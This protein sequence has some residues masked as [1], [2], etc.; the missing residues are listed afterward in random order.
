MSA[1]ANARLGE[2]IWQ[3]MPKINAEF[4]TLT[5]GAMV[6][7]LM[8]DLEDVQLV[9]EKLEKMGHSIG[10]R[11]IDEFLAKSGINNCNEFA[12]TADVIAKVA[13]KMFLG[14]SV[15]VASWNDEKTSC[16]LLVYDNPLTDFVE[17]PPNIN[18]YYSNVLCGVIRGALEMVQL[19][20]ECYFVRD[21]LRGDDVNEIRLELKEHIKDE[22]AEEY[23]RE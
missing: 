20:V 19:R 7:Q 4:F 23:R 18:L 9:N 15:E 2:Q 3:K 14:V 11:L 22:M 8:R 21:T 16:S 1:S 17:L 6:V 12:E 10:C 13:F 5:Y